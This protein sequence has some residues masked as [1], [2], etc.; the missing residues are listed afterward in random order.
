MVN[1]NSDYPDMANFHAD[2][3]ECDSLTSDQVEVLMAAYS[4]AIFQEINELCAVFVSAMDTLGMP[5]SQYHSILRS[6]I[7]YIAAEG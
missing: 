1:F 2:D 5:R 3:P 7:E 4:D 6:Y